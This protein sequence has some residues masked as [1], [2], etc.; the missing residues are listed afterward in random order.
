MN[1]T[2]TLG[3]VIHQIVQDRGEQ[4]LTNTQRVQALFLDMAPTMTREQELLRAFLLCDGANKLLQ[5]KEKP[6]SNQKAAMENMVKTLNTERS[7]D[8]DAARYV[9]AE[10]YYGITGKTWTFDTRKNADTPKSGAATKPRNQSPRN[11]DIYTTTVVRNL[12][13]RSGKYTT[14]DVDGNTVQIKIPENVVAGQPRKYS[15]K[16]RKDPNSGKYGDLYVTFQSR[17]GGLSSGF[18]RILIA[19]AV[20]LMLMLVGS[21]LFGSRDSDRTTGNMPGSAGNSAGQVHTHTW[22]E[23]TYAAPKTCSVCGASEG[24]SLGTPLPKCSVEEDTQSYKKTDIITGTAW[25]KS[26]NQYKDAITFWVNNGAGYVEVEH[27]VYR[28]S[29]MYDRLEGLIALGGDS[30]LGASVRICIYGDG[31]LLYIGNYIE[32]NETEAIQ[33]DVSGVNEL[34][35][36]CDTEEACHCYGILAAEL[37]VE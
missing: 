7:I 13:S 28:L 26:G 27:I 24:L 3:D 30:D 14:V 1:K 4:E 25:D 5:V 8:I 2:N 6:A 11:L 21:R 22:E 10:V 16:G 32:G 18:I 36:E 15:G 12:E 19:A 31:K 34:K 23:A 33:L 29:G 35:I 37:Y 9:C 20:I 17:R